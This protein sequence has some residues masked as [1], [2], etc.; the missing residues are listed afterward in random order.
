MTHRALLDDLIAKLRE[1]EE[2]LSMASLE[3]RDQSLL[4]S[5]IRHLLILAHY[6]LGKLEDMAKSASP[7]TKADDQTGPDA[8]T[9]P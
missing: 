3:A 5:R 9:P 4:R 2:Q 1:M 7:P 8:P 6:V